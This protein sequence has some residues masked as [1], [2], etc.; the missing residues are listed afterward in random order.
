MHSWP[1]TA[2][3]CDSLGTDYSVLPRFLPSLSRRLTLSVGENPL[4]KQWGTWGVVD[5][6]GPLP[7]RCGVFLRTLGELGRKGWLTVRS[8]AQ[9]LCRRV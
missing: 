6:V 2:C 9:L 5:R 3:C 1:N 4:R 8:H 7:R